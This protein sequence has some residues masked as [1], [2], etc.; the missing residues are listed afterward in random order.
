V[1]PDGDRLICL[2]A[3]GEPV[4]FRVEL[5]VEAGAAC[6]LRVRL[7][8]M[9]CRDLAFDLGCETLQKRRLRNA[10]VRSIRDLP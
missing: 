9:T 6:S 5:A 7:E 8:N 4:G 2:L 1:P 10:S 3:D